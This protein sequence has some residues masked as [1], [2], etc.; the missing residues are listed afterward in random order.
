M[1][2]RSISIHYNGKKNFDWVEGN[3]ARLHTLIFIDPFPLVARRY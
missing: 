3:A 2:K 1:L